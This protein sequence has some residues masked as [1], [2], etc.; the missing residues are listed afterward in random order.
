M[1]VVGQYRALHGNEACASVC[2]R[3]G[4]DDKGPVYSPI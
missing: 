4:K 1:N 2:I 3:V